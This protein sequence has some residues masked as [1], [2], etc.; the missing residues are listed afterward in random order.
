MD[1]QHNVHFTL[2]EAREVLI[3]LIPELE[4][5]R[6]LKRKLDAMGYDIRGHHF[7]AGM[8]TNG[9]KPYPDEVNELIERFRSVTGR[10]V[11]VKDMETGLVDFPA[12]RANGREVYLCF[13]LGEPTIEY[14][15]EIEEGFAGRHPVELL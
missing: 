4:K 12:L 3:P 1:Y 6:D 5:I 13:R 14:W 10:G 11:L 2:Q 8:G 9:T 7:F 15:H